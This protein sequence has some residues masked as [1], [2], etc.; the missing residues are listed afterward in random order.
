MNSMNRSKEYYAEGSY[1]EA[2]NEINGIS[3][4]DVDKDYYNQ[5]RIMG[6]IGMEYDSYNDYIELNMYPQAIESLLKGVKAFNE[7]EK[8]A[9]D[10][11]IKGQFTDMYN[12]I[13]GLLSDVFS[14]SIEKA[15][16][17]IEMDDR[18]AYSEF[19]YE[20]AQKAKK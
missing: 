4:K 6:K 12:R 8:D 3:V 20:T 9:G 7:N 18:V 17:L 11:G 5:A 1:V 10:L 14:I 16:E 15:N 2:F 19:I 13:T